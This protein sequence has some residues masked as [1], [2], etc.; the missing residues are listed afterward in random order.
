MSQEYE[1]WIEL[2]DCYLKQLYRIFNDYFEGYEYNSFCKY[3]YTK[4]Y[5]N[6]NIYLIKNELKS[7]I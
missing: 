5:L 7:I 4:S 1:Y 6:K 2:Y 3:I